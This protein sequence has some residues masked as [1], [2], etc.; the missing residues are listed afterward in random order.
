MALS[1]N[2][3]FEI[4]A[5]AFRKM[6]GNWPPGK[7]WPATAGPRNEQGDREAWDDWCKVYSKVVAHVLDATNEVL[8]SDL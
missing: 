7:D 4:K 2:E 3:R 5:L 8:G 6:T 1:I